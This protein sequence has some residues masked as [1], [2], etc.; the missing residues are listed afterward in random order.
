MRMQ[1]LLA[2]LG[3][4]AVFPV[5]CGGDSAAVPEGTPVAQ[6]VSP[7]AVESPRAAYEAEQERIQQAVDAFFSDP[8]NE[9]YQGKR[10]Y[11]LNGREKIFL[12][13]G[14]VTVPTL[15]LIDNGDPF[16][17]A[18]LFNPVAGT[19]GAALGTKWTDDGDGTRTI[20]ASSGDT[21]ATVDVSEP[22]NPGTSFTDPRYFFIDLETLVNEGF[23]LEM[24][25]SASPDNKPTWA[26]REYDGSY[27]WY[28]NDRGEVKSLLSR[29]PTKVGFVDGVFP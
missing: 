6:G 24:P 13:H 29:D 15:E 1:P 18:S 17:T 23:L 11:P 4:V 7:A 2:L 22:G 9:T 14:D 8:N 21:W 27:I 25:K 3:I 12:F 16:T 5:A 28:L 10:Q 26:V 20:S 19:V